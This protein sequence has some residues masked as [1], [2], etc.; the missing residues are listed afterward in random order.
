MALLKTARKIGSFVKSGISKRKKSSIAL[1]G[2]AGAA[3]I[4][5]FGRSQKRKGVEFGNRQ[6]R[7]DLKV[8]RGEIKL[9]KFGQ[10]LKSKKPR[11]LKKQGKRG[12]ARIEK[13]KVRRR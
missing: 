13:L 6:G 4:A 10:V 11:K 12:V 1:A 7:F 9:G 5:K 3:G 8:E 2:L